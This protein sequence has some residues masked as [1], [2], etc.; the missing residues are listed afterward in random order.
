MVTFSSAANE[1]LA[2]ASSFPTK[3][4]VHSNTIELPCNVK[5]SIQQQMEHSKRGAGAFG[6]VAFG[7]AASTIR[8]VSIA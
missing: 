4:H 3:A 2:V 8:I 7:D 6:I 1:R 5:R